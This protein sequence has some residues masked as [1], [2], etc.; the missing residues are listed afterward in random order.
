[1]TK[2]VCK[3]ETDDIGITNKAYE[4][5][6]EKNYVSESLGPLKNDWHKT[7]T[8]MPTEITAVRE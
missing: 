7:S 8:C 1:V 4:I 6:Q 2:D 5:Q 3:S